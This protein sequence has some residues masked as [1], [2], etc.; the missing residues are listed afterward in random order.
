MP[1]GAVLRQGAY[2]CLM[3]GLQSEGG[4]KSVPL[5]DEGDNGPERTFLRVEVDKWKSA[6]NISQSKDARFDFD[7]D[8]AHDRLTERKRKQ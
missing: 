1:F 8:P 3:V 7:V 5:G 6:P 2:G 4:S